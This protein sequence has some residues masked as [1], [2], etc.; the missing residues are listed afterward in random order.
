M[1]TTI[2]VTI[3][4]TIAS[5]GVNAN[6]PAT[7]QT[8]VQNVANF[9]MMDGQPVNGGTIVSNLNNVATSTVFTIASS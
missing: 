5:P 8:L 4:A 2:T 7:V 3:T 9:I 1:A 6:D